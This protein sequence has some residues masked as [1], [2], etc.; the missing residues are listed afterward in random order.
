MNLSSVLSPLYDS[1]LIILGAMVSL[2]AFI[3]AAKKTLYLLDISDFGIK[4]QIKVDDRRLKQ[5]KK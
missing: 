3:F 5:F 1:L 4:R 2:L